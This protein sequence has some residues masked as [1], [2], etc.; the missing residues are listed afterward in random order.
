MVYAQVDTWF[1]N[2]TTQ[3]QLAA[4]TARFDTMASVVQN[5]IYHCNP[6]DC[7]DTTF[8][9]VY[10]TRATQDIYMCS[11]VLTYPD[12]AEQVQ[13]VIH[14]LSHFDHIADT[15]DNF[16]GEQ[17]CY[18]LG[19]TNFSGALHTAD[20]FGYYAIYSD[21]CYRN[22][23][24]DYSV[25]YPP[26]KDCT[27]T[28]GQRGAN[29]C[30]GTSNIAMNAR[31]PWLDDSCRYANDG[32]CDEPTYCS[33]YTDFTDCD[34][35]PNL[36]THTL[37]SANN[38]SSAGEMCDYYHSMNW[39]CGGCHNCPGGWGTSAPTTAAP[40]T[41][42]TNS[43]TNAPTQQCYDINL[44]STA[45]SSSV[46]WTDS[47]GSDDCA[48]Y[49]STSTSTSTWC[50]QYGDSYA[51][52]GLT[53]NQACCGCGGGSNTT[54]YDITLASSAP[55]TDSGGSDT[56]GNCELKSDQPAVIVCGAVQVAS[57][58]HH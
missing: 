14:E 40:T 8:A 46:P 30:S 25:A 57:R 2:S 4:V 13:T 10:P 11:Y 50:I 51:N 33:L 43:P 23:P 16:Y 6:T 54:C 35:T 17:P 48:K 18:T 53:A 9:Y 20:S 36:T 55:W 44:A 47:G 5:T 15:D 29:D 24:S 28:T 34:N 12:Y 37:T 38:F 27:A 19:Q 31:A 22:A 32:T 49:A 56:I 42:P 26:C 21:M 52:Q 58:Q 7:S 45:A 39:D 41:T 1:G 3:T